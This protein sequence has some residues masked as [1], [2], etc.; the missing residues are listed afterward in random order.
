MKIYYENEDEIRY[1]KCEVKGINFL[2]KVTQD[3]EDYDIDIH[4]NKRYEDI[5]EEES[6]LSDV[7]ELVSITYE[8]DTYCISKGEFNREL[9]ILGT[10]Q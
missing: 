2:I 9:N 1:F 6:L 4:Y 10:R 8:E 3:D 7:R 5:I